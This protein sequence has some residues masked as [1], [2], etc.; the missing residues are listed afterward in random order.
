MSHHNRR[1]FL[2]ALLVTA[3]GCAG[4]GYRVYTTRA[5]YLLRQGQR[6]LEGDHWDKAEP[7]AAALES[8]GHPAHAHLLR[9]E[10]WVR[11]GRLLL[12]SA[13]PDGTPDLEASARRPQAL[14][15]LRR[16]L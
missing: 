2:V 7:W 10:V 5:S 3:L 8:R 9:G 12:A 1:T 13:A 6:A 16:A 15:A 11:K 4:L 14:A